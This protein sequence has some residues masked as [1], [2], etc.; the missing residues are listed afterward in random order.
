MP[1]EIDGRRWHTV[2]RVGRTG[3]PCRWDGRIL[4]E[5]IDR[6]QEQVRPVRRDRLERAE[7]GR[8]SRGEEIGRLVLP[9]HHR[10]GVAA[11][12]EVPHG[13]EHVQARGTGREARPEA[14]E[15]HARPAALRHRAARAVQESSRA[16]AGDRAARAQLRRDRPAGVLGVRRSGGGRLRQVHREGA[17]EVRH[18]AALEAT[19]PHVALRPQ[20]VF[21]SA[22]RSIGRWRCWKT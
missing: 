5:V 6:I 2:D 22:R 12:D 9:R 20:G 18:P 17:G 19:R 8:D 7:R 13:A 21:R 15:R 11:E 4:A 10:R 1:W 16:V 3:N 14:A